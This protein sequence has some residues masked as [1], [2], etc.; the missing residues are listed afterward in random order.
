M[1]TPVAADDII[2]A[3]VHI[4]RPDRGST[5]DS[6]IVGT[7]VMLLALSIACRVNVLNGK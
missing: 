1:D 4:V 7:P 6:A 2:K 5:L 3:Q